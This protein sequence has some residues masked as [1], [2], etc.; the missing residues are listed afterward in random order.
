MNKKIINVIWICKL[1][2]L[3]YNCQ[4]YYNI[5]VHDKVIIN[6]VFILTILVINHIVRIIR[7]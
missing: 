4:L 2:D 6:D 5:N 7:A 1:E 3:I